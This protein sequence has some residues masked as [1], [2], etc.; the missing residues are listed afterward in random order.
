MLGW[1]LFRALHGVPP[2]TGPESYSAGGQSLPLPFP[3]VSDSSPRSA[4]PGRARASRSTPARA[5]RSWN[6][7][8]ALRSTPQSSRRA[9]PR[10]RTTS[11]DRLQ[12]TVLRYGRCRSIAGP[13]L[14][15]PVDYGFNSKPSGTQNHLPGRKRD[16]GTGH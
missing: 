15:H 6:R 13:L 10:P 8:P 4:T 12:A 14:C 3:A 9:G 1:L 7:Q 11:G 5:P 2:T 16:A